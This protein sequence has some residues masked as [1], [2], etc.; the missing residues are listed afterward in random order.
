MFYSRSK[1]IFLLSAFHCFSGL[2]T[3][4]RTPRQ[5]AMTSPSPSDVSPTWPWHNAAQLAC[6]FLLTRDWFSIALLRKSAGKGGERHKSWNPLCSGHPRL[7]HCQKR[8]RGHKPQMRLEVLFSSGRESKH[9]LQNS[10]RQQSWCFS[11]ATYMHLY[12]TKVL[13]DVFALRLLKN[14]LQN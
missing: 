12:A 1:N 3:A 7:N 2:Q 8:P 9:E 4:E 10:K 6:N 11:R 13:S 5:P 14:K